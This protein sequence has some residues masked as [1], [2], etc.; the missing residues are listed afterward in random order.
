MKARAAVRNLLGAAA[1]LLILGVGNMSL[2]TFKERQY[3][4]ILSSAETELATR[5]AEGTSPLSDPAIAQ[6][7]KLQKIERIKARVGFY[8]FIRAGGEFFLAASFLCVLA[9]LWLIN[10]AEPGAPDSDKT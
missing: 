3:L 1:I 10:W 8:E 4:K 9:I 7:Q 5:Q 6:D 2:G